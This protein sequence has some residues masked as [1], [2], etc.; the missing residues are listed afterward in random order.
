M[1]KTI[2][3][4]IA[5][6]L[7][8]S[9]ICAAFAEVGNRPSKGYAAIDGT[10]VVG[11]AEGQNYTYQYNITATGST[12]QV[13]A[14]QIPAGKYMVE[15]DTTPSGG[16]VTIPTCVPGTQFILYNNGA[17]TL[18]VYPSLANNPATGVQD[19]INNQTSLG[20]GTGLATHTQTAFACI[21][22]GVWS[23][24]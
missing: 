1:I 19:T 10:W 18:N 21:K 5:G 4:M 2:L 20:N 24:S 11:L 17:Q 12:A 23:S 22:A 14:A 13:G 16:S 7:I 3:N 9:G 8:F 6:A 15:V